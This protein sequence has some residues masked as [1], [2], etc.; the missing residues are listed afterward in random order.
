MPSQNVSSR[1]TKGYS[2]KS[3]KRNLTRT[4][5]TQGDNFRTFLGAFMGAMPSTELLYR[6]VGLIGIEAVKLHPGGH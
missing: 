4:W 2:R 6:S 5:R 1:S 3:L